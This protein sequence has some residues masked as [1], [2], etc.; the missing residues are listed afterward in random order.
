MVAA[1]QHPNIK[2]LTYSEVEEIGGYVGNFTVKIR[3][4]ARLVDESKCTG[5]GL[6]QEKC[7]TKV[8]SEFDCGLGQRKAIYTPFPQAVPNVPVIDKENCRLFTKGRCGICQK[9]CPAKAIDY[10]QQ[11]EIIEEK[12]GAIIVATGYD[13]FAWE[14]AYGEYG[15]GRYPDVISGMHFERMAS[16][17]GPTGGKI[18][19]PSDGQEPK[20]VVFIKCA[21]S[22]D[23]T[24]GKSYCSRAC[25]MYTA[26]HAHQVLDKIPDSQ[27]IV[28]YMDVR[29]PGKAYDEFYERTVEEGAVYLRGRVSKI[30]PREGKLVVKGED[31]LLGCPVEVEA[32][33]VV[34]ATAMVPAAGYEKVAKLASISMDKDGWFQEAHPKLRPVET[35]TAGVFLA[36]ACQGPKDIPDTV[37]QASAAAVKVTSLFSKTEMPTDPMVATVDN[38][39]CA[40]CGICVGVCPYKAIELVPLQE[41][42]A[43]KMQERMVAAVNKGLCQGCGACNVA[44][45]SGAITVKGFTDQQILAEVEA[46]CL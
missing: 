4:K 45:R 20:T 26:K 22:R 30:Y 24:K 8:P 14:E 29:T 46:L 3:K 9:L 34:L 35:F 40:G 43:G 16:A 11:D 37:S 31:T 6:C 19:R 36:G 10:E 39:I 32:D 42:V 38:A 25:C 18:I 7:P 28:F 23:L 12:F 17:S 41:R 44:C 15:Y 1:A 2:T 33:L 13:L 5:C 21:G 27:A